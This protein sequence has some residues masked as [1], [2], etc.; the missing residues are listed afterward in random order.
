MKAD[1]LM[2][3]FERISDA[4]DAV[5]RLRRFILDLAVRGKLVEQDS[6]DEPADVL[7]D[8]IALKKAESS[9]R[10][11]T[12]T[13]AETEADPYPLPPSWAWTQIAELGR[14]SPRNEADNSAV[15]SFVPMCL[16]SAAYGVEAS[17][18]KRPWGEIK[19]GYTHIAEGDV[20][21]AKI[22]PCFENGKSTVFR[23]LTGGIGAGTTELHVVR[24]I[25]TSPDYIV[26]F[27]KSPFFI[28]TGISLMTGTAG[29]KRLPGDYFA[30]RP[31]PLPPL[32]EQK[33]IVA[34][35]DELMM[36]CDRLEAS[37][38]EREGRR[39]RLVMASLNRLS[40]P[41]DSGEFKKDAQ[42]QL[43]NLNRLSTK[44][45]H[46]KE[47]RKAILNLAVS[48]K[49][50]P[51]DEREGTAANSLRTL[52][53]QPADPPPDCENR[54][55]PSSWC[56]IRFDDVATISGGVTLGRKLGGRK[57]ASVP[58]L[59]V[60]NVQRGGFD[61]SII[62]EVDVPVEEVEKYSLKENDLLM[63]EGGDWDKVGRS[64]IWRNQIPLC[65][66]QNHVF[67][68]RIKS[69]EMSPVWFERYFNSP[70]GRAYFES[71]S[72]QTTNLASINMRQVRGCPIPLPPLAEQKRIVAKVD[73]L[74]LICDQLENK[75]QYQQKGRR[76][77]LEALLHEALEG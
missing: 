49:L 45:E 50:V 12:R 57:T 54:V 46:I 7:L 36:L 65:L 15:C 13:T 69:P 77:L 17:H 20:A 28:E 63:T 40:Q 6:G 24:P 62:K 10:S 27:L 39:D 23:N 9:S 55:L 66:H 21:V 71:C 30:Y 47:I 48:G 44:P 58:Y 41:T 29:Q 25:E 76:Q 42:F 11:K 32:A 67:R 37:R 52:G 5:S 3:H 16:I 75:L 74:M 64:A 22:T 33:R 59:R 61:L 68:A 56:M 19:K 35:V 8:R 53:L 34:K 2:A 31:F 18:E 60:A 73:E 14:L 38:A 51:Q 70:A 43:S 4:P 1:K 26:L 72:K